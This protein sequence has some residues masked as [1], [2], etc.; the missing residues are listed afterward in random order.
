MRL[1]QTPLDTCL[2]SPVLCQPL[3]SRFALQ[4]Y[5]PSSLNTVGANSITKIIETIEFNSITKIIRN[6]FWNM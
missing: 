4:V 6:N 3:S 1:F 2:D 5:A